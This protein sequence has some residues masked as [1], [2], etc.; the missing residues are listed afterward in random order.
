[1]H[2]HTRLNGTVVQNQSTSDLV[3]DIPTLIETL[4][5]G[6]TLQPGD[7]IATG[8]PVGVGASTGRFLHGGDVVN[9]AIEGLGELENRVEDGDGGGAVR[10]MREERAG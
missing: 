4:S 10:S 3:F 5:M 9:V 6:I 7:V 2:I 8:T 1:M